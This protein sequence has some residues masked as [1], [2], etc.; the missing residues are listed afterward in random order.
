M[1]SAP[2]NQ[3]SK[4]V[5]GIVLSALFITGVT[6]VVVYTAPAPAPNAPNVSIPNQDNG[7]TPA[8]ESSYT[9][10]P[11]SEEGI[12]PQTEPIPWSEENYPEYED[13]VDYEVDYQ[14][15]NQYSFNTLSIASVC[16]FHETTHVFT[17]PYI[18]CVVDENMIAQEMTNGYT[19][20]TGHT[21]SV[22]LYAGLIDGDCVDY[23]KTIQCR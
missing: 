4:V 18:E 5:S 10:N 3:N 17:P 13:E 8:P 20:F 6:L 23:I 9:P 12:K 15:S 21:S 22:D 7:M 2:V 19:S 14:V 11:E 1:S 16:I